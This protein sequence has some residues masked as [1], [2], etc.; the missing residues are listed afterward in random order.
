MYLRII[1]KFRK[2]FWKSS[3]PRPY[4]KHHQLDQVI[5]RFGQ[6]SINLFMDGESISISLGNLYQFMIILVVKN[7]ILIYSLFFLVS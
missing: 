3:S 7:F 1:E 5:K 4:F 2:N 6:Y